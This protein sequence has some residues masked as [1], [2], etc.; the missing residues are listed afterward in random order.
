MDI[1]E[2]IRIADAIVSTQLGRPLSDCERHVLQECWRGKRFQEMEGWAEKTLKDTGARL[3]KCFEQALGGQIRVSKSTFQAALTRLSKDPRYSSVAQSAIP[4]MPVEVFSSSCHPFGDRG[5][6]T[7]PARFF[8]R[9]EILRRIFEGLRRGCSQSLVG[10][11][12]IGKSSILSMICIQGPQQLQL[13]QSAF[14]LMD[15]QCIDDEQDFFVALCDELGIDP[16]CRGSHLRRRVRDQHYIICL[17]E[18]EKMTHPEKFSGEERSELRGLAGGSTYPFTLVIA[19]RSPLSQLFPDSPEKTSPLAGICDPQIDV[20]PF[21]LDI[22]K[23][24]I[25]HRL[26]GTNIVFSENQINDLLNRSQGHPAR[27]QEY[28]TE[29]YDRLT[30]Q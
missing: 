3:W 18:V 26:R 25:E 21:S 7:D 14:I 11:S 1:D 22:A 4:T 20:T 8:D 10:E 30:K 13:P 9:K 6:I 15:M 24:F 17:D 27:L 28:A 19:S 23:A 16:P 29:L 12:Q 2:I 5:C